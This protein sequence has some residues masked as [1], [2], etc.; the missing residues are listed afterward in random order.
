M[1]L[2]PVS[3]FL[4]GGFLPSHAQ[5][6][7]TTEWDVEIPVP[8]SN[9][10]Q[11]PPAPKPSPIDFKVQSSMTTRMEVVV[12]DDD[13]IIGVN[14]DSEVFYAENKE[15][16][17]HIPSFEWITPKGSPVTAPTDTGD[18]KNEFVYDTSVNA[19]LLLNLEIL[20]K[21]TGTVNLTGHD[22]VKFIDRCAFELPE[23][24][25]STFGWSS[26]DNDDGKA[27]A[28]GEYLIA[29]ATYTTLPEQNTSFGLKQAKFTCDDDQESIAAGD[30]DAQT[31][32]LFTEGRF[33]HCF[34]HFGAR[35]DQYVLRRAGG[36]YQAVPAEHLVAW[37]RFGN[38]GH[39][40]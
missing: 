37:H 13:H 22:G 15:A 28:D 38:S 7:T 35:F 8:V 4:L 20:V 17:L 10:K 25:G 5:E 31:F 27:K 12:K 32:K 14:N 11:T 40:G 19:E 3:L 33:F 16:T 26:P 18:G 24:T 21:P 36:R 9:G 1:N 34:D 23:I 39:I 30:F 29:E 2:L 6:K